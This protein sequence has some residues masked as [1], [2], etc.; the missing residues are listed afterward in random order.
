MTDVFRL[1]YIVGDWAYFTTQ[2]LTEQWG[3]DWNDAPYEH[4]AGRP[5]EWRD[6][7]EPWEILKVAFEGRFYR[8]CDGTINS[9]WAVRDINAGAVPWLEAWG[10]DGPGSTLMAGATYDEFVE[11]VERHGGTVYVE[12]NSVRE[13]GG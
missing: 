6:D 12:W 2:A 13:R 4:N 1:C 3:D 8:P 10:D 7:G 11:F 5:Y 9:A